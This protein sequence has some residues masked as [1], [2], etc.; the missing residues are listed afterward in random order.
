MKD[1]DNENDDEEEEHGEREQQQRAEQGP[2]AGGGGSGLQT[3]ENAAQEK[4]FRRE[5][6]NELDFKSIFTPEIL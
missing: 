4:T 2:P 5:F 3:L 6:D 1:D